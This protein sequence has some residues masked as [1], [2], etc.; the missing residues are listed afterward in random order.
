M[1]CKVRIQ[2]LGGKGTN[3]MNKVAENL[4]EFV[5]KE[6]NSRYT[7]KG[8]IVGYSHSKDLAECGGLVNIYLAWSK[9][10]LFSGHPVVVTSNKD[11]KD[12][13]SLVIDDV[14][15]SFPYIVVV[16][17][18]YQFRNLSALEHKN[19]VITRIRDSLALE[20]SSLNI[21]DLNKILNEV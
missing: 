6:D 12:M 18:D 7:G 3:L 16:Q 4:K 5:V 11:L 13:L 9:G 15:T 19:S 17:V 1:L 10:I 2:H 21:E 8:Y 20:T 14:L